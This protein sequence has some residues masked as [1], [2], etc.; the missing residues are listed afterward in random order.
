MQT[1]VISL[2]GSVII[3]DGVDFKFLE[4]F[5]A[6][7]RKHYKTH[8][9]VI[10]CGGGSIARKYID[11]LSQEHRTETQLAIAGIRATRMNALFMIQFFGKEANQKLPLDMKEV[12]DSLKRHNIVFCGALRFRPHSTSDGTTARLAHY[13][14]TD[15]INI[16]NVKGLYTANPAT[17][18]DA[19]FI[20]KISWK[21]LEKM[22]L[23]LKFKAGQ[24]FILDQEA[25]TLIKQ[26]RT[27]TYIIGRELSNLA[28]IIKGNPF[29]GTEISG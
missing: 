11:A 4:K 8:K 25:A 17:H 2:G 27:K 7:V 5:K 3:P 29:T 22:A 28:A 16:T 26:N 1:L 14:K 12:K 15:F 21:S 10:V 23:D 20:P 18:K 19:K 13:L 9:F 24:H 6:I